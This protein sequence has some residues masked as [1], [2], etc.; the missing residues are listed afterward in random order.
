MEIEFA[1]RRRQGTGRGAT[2]IAIAVAVV[3][4]DTQISAADLVLHAAASCEC[5]NLS[6]ACSGKLV[7]LFLSSLLL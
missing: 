1:K 7:S 4:K 2:C 6:L 3:L 5:S